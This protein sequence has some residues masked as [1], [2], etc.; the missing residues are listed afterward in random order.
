[1]YQPFSQDKQEQSASQIS[2]ATYV[3]QV[4]LMQKKIIPEGISVFG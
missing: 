1:M 4:K 3:Y 2:Q